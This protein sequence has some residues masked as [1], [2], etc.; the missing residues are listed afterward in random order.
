MVLITV[1]LDLWIHQLQYPIFLPQLPGLQSSLLSMS[2]LLSSSKCCILNNY[3]TLK[4][5]NNQETPN[6]NASFFFKKFYASCFERKS[7]PTNLSL[8]YIHRSEYYSKR[9]VS[10]ARRNC[11]NSQQHQ[12]KASYI[13]ENT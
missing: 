6:P 3:S 7:F 11:N 5:R 1:V 2:M 12:S 13:H 9:N 8:P 4:L 10:Q